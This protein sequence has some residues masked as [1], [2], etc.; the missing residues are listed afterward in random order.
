[1]GKMWRWLLPMLMVAFAAL[2]ASARET[3]NFISKPLSA[4]KAALTENGFYLDRVLGAANFSPDLRL[5]V[6]L[7]YKSSSE[8]TGMFGFGWSSPQLESSATPEKDGVLW[9]TPWG[10]QIRFFEKERPTKETLDLHREGMKGRGKYYSPYAQWEAD[11]RALKDKRSQTGDW[12]FTGKRGYTGWKFIYRDAKLM[13]VTAPSG[14]TLRFSHNRDRLASVSQEGLR[15]IELRYSG[16]LVS[17]MVLNGVEY[18]FV[19]RNNMV[20]LLPKTVQA[21]AMQIRVPQLAGY[22]QGTLDSVTFAYDSCGYLTRVARGD[23]RDDL[24]VQHESEAERLAAL[25]Q[26]AEKKRAFGGGVAGRL[27]ADSM[28][29]YAYGSAESGRVTLTDRLGR[30]ADYHYD[31]KTGV[32]NIS[33][34]SG[35]KSTIYY[36]MRYDVAY[37][38]KVRKIVDGRGRTV[39]SYRYDKLTGNVIRI[40]D[41]AGNDMNFAYNDFGEVRLVTRRGAE[42]DSPEPVA[43][44]RY[45]SRRNLTEVMRLD[46]SGRAVTTTSIR[47][48]GANQPQRI[49]DGRTWRELR[50]NRFGLVMTETDMFRRVVRREYDGVNRLSAVT[51]ADGTKTCYTYNENGQLVRMERLDGETRLSLLDIAY[52]GDGLPVKYTDGRG[53]SKSFDR[54]AFGRVVR[55]RF[56]DATEVEY[57]YNALGQLSRVID[58]NGNEIRFSWDRFGL[59][60]K[61]T[62]ANQLTDYVY[63]ETGLLREILSKYR[64]EE[65]VDRKIA[66]EYDALDRLVKVTYDGRDVETFC[67]DTWGK[68]IS[69]SRNGRKA[70]YRYDYFGRLVEKNEDGVITRSSYNAWGQ[71]TGR[72]TVNGSLKLTETREYDALGR[73][74]K[75]RNG[76]GGELTYHYDNLNR[77]VKQ[78]VN[79]VP[80]EYSYD[81]YGRLV[82]K[83]LMGF[84]GSPAVSELKY[85]YDPDGTIIAREVNGV[86]QAYKYDRRGQLLEVVGQERYAYDPAGNILSKTVNGVTTTYRYDRA[87]QLVSSETEGKVTKYAYD[88]AGRLVK[89]GNKSYTYAWLDK[90]VSVSEAGKVSA[91]FSYHFDGQIAGV[92]YADGRRENYLW[93]GL[94][95]IHRDGTELL[96]EPAVTGGNPVLSGD[97]VLFNDMLGNTLGVKGKDAYQPIKMT[98]F[99]ESDNVDAFFTGKPLVGEL[100]YAFLFRNYRPGQGKWQTADPLGYPDGWNN[101]AYVN[102]WVIFSIDPLGT[103]IVV[104]GSDEYK[105][106]VQ[107]ALDQMNSTPTGA[108]ILKQLNESSNTHTISQGSNSCTPEN[109]INATNNTGANTSVSYDPSVTSVEGWDR[110]SWAGLAHE[111]VHSSEADLGKIDLLPDSGSGIS[112]AEISACTETN[113]MLKEN[114][115]DATMRTKYGNKP[116]PPGAINPVPKPRPE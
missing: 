54:D 113:R 93:D 18:R 112:N 43:G 65:K 47:Y 60:E 16:K 55:E 9:K 107:A 34:F 42:Q 66:R 82:R 21:K 2:S 91:N 46:A 103:V 96:N 61:A 48:D 12:T 90:L 13:Q 101:F 69:S 110:P 106:S 71:R 59:K 88:A 15:L 51:A 57:G 41:M 89:E 10:E 53:R 5:P 84:S 35:R 75:I 63:D 50:Y 37:L 14:R 99:G 76:S 92:T 26:A 17:S 115:P 29:N 31:G 19:Y 33:E 20:T 3:L 85:F 102:N 7:F 52:G 25:R 78:T 100:G 1:M 111:L 74:S 109:I 68:V 83:A 86:R 24:K 62:A 77:L 56:P 4:G 87:N 72:E 70:S 58:Q 105:A 44:F 104:N 22:R 40:R 114:D 94:A 38:G 8:S 73:L 98:A 108:A 95:L 6:Q 30:K 27:L 81:K 36:F 64:G 97:K 11:T 79:G 49:S 45:D 39:V 116:L 23:Y 32:F 80:V 28:L 67:Y